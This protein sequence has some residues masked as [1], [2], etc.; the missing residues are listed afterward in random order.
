MPDKNEKTKCHKVHIGPKNA[1]CPILKVHDT[2]MENVQEDTYLG[3]V[4]SCD[5]RNTKNIKK[6]ISKGLGIITEILYLLEMV[7][8][9]EHFIEIAT[10]FREALF[11]NAII[12]NAENW[13]GFS[14]SE[15]EEFEKLDRLQLRKILQVP[16][17][18]PQESF[19]LEL[20][21][22]PIGVLIKARRINFLRY[23]LSRDE[24]EM[25]FQAF[26]AQWR[27][28]CKLEIKHEDQN[29]PKSSP[30][31]HLLA[32]SLPKY[33]ILPIQF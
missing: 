21:I 33:S 5:G 17:S 30:F 15:I 10:L 3:D 31:L 23:L 8:L 27:N 14:L 24:E 11:V 2:T 22:M 29:S 4:I 19:Y 16:V 32:N 6:R 12:T 1:T 26:I 9:G 20:G 18:T 13:Y 28:P 7:S 25:P